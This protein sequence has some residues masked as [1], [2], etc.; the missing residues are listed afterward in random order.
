MH[1]LCIDITLLDRRIGE[2]LDQLTLLDLRGDG[3][4]RALYAAARAGSDDPLSLQAARALLAAGGPVLLLTGFRV[5]PWG[6]PE[7]DGLI[8]T[9]VLAAALDRAA[10]TRV[11]CVAEPEVTGPLAAVL[12][13]A[14]L[15]V[16]AQVGE[17]SLLPHVVTILP[18]P[19]L[20]AP[21]LADLVAPAACVAIERP[22]RNDRGRY[23]MARGRDVTDWI[24]PV[25][26]LWD[27]LRRRGVPTVAIG[28]FGNEL[29]MGGIADAVR[30]ETPAGASCGCGCGGGVA[31]ASP[32]DVTVACSVSD[33][34]AYALAACVSHLARRDAGALVGRDV[35]RRVCEA[36]VAAGAIDGA[37]TLAIPH[38]DG[39]DHRFNRRLLETMRDAVAYPDR[40]A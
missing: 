15:A 30:R 25:D 39:V 33:W 2:N 29:G 11:A 23:H 38:I 24:A 21:A 17:A 5:P 35:Y 20:G 22:G 28:D 1:L 9:A 6:V 26:D 18:Y 31:A 13:A 7:T 12:R 34:G 16:T 40:R 27:E 4:A 10:G 8:G 3:V 14:G 19:G 36:A 32:A 37:S